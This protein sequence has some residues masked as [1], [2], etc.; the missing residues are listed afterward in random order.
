MQIEVDSLKELEPGKTYAIQL[1]GWQ[2]E[3]KLKMIDKNIAAIAR[4]ERISF[5]LFDEDMR[6]I[7]A[8]KEIVDAG[9]K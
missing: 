4:C 8:P 9:G 3:E 2:S 5:I 1:V 6:L 7:D